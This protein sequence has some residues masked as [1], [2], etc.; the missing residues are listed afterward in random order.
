M[1]ITWY[2]EGCFKI[3]EGDFVM[4]TDPFLSAVGLTPPRLK[5]NVLLKTLTAF[6]L[7]EE[8]PE[9]VKTIYG[10]GEYTIDA[11]RI[12]GIAVP[13][14]STD[15]FMKTAYVVTL[16]TIH[17]CFLGHISEFPDPAL[18]EHMED[19]DI[20]FLPAGGAPFLD[21]KSAAKI[22]KQLEPSIVIPS[23]FKVPGL[24]RQTAD[25]HLFLKEMG[26]G[27][28]APQDKIALRKKELSEIKTTRVML[29]HP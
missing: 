8:P 27:Q 18:T 2:G 23:F 15:T 22:V 17:L 11:A 14:E 28:A 16:D 9:G 12:H 13:R 19:V 29:L 3:Q 1:V 5:P 4:L 10:P 20:L 21:Q 26:N 6:P 7:K 24:K 25:A